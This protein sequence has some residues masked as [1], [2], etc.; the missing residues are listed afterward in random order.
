MIEGDVTA[1]HRGREKGAGGFADAVTFSGILLILALF[2]GTATLA[3]GLA[4]RSPEPVRVLGP[5]PDPTVAGSAS[6]AVDPGQAEPVSSAPVDSDLFGLRARV[7]VWGLDGPTAAVAI[8]S[9]DAFFVLER[10]G[11]VRV[12]SE[13]EIRPEPALDIS[14]QVST[15][16]I[17]R[18]LIGIALHPQWAA[19]G[20][21]FISFTDRDGSLRLAEYRSDPRSLMIDRSSEQVLLVVD[22]ADE[23]LYHLGGPIAFGPDGH[24]W[25]G[26]GDGSNPIGA[27][28][29]HHGPNPHTLQGALARIDVDAGPGYAIPATNPFSDG[30]GGAAEVWAFGF[31]NPWSFTFDRGHVIVADVGQEAYEEI[32]VIP[33]NR[34]GGFYGWSWW[35]GNEC[36]LS[37]GCGDSA[38]APTL[39][40]PHEEI[41]AIIGGP[42]YRGDA[43]PE[44]TGRYFYGDFCS[45]RIAGI[46]LAGVGDASEPVDIGQLEFPVLT[47]VSNFVVD[48]EG[49]VYAIQF[50]WGRMVKIEPVRLSPDAG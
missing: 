13:G 41:C 19:S 7:F 29:Y 43:I 28:T 3:T 21:V 44:L 15:D 5:E 12:V 10:P 46:S 32:N 11:R 47:G 20:R 17:E 16:A 26:L 24:L 35:E 27:D 25:I 39:V 37:I 33:L 42:V 18:G 49:E 8:P 50:G 40:F 1:L 2:T 30:L 6:V 45:G 38:V 48:S 14:D 22:H 31:R 23:G 9:T 4:L 34:P 36:V